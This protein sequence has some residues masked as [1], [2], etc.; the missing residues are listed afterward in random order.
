M[1]TSHF[2]QQQQSI[3]QSLQQQSINQSQQQQS[4]NQSQQQQS[5]N[6]SQQQQDSRINS[7]TDIQVLEMVD[8][9]LI[10]YHK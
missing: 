3:N 5:I 4:I 9:L 8:I 7:S 6:Q 10:I 1:D 2:Q